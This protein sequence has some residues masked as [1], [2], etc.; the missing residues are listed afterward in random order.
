[1]SSEQNGS[2]WSLIH[3][4]ALHADKTIFH[5]IHTTDTMLASKLIQLLHNAKWVQT[6][7]I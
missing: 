3:A 1:M 5:H 7:T 4:A 2:T 6:L